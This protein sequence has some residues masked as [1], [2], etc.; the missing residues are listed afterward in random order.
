MTLIINSK[1][2]LQNNSNEIPKQILKI[3]ITKNFISL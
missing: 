3:E 1:L 2:S